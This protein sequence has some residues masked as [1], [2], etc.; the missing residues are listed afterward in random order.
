MVT[1]SPH[2]ITTRVEY[3]VEVPNLDDQGLHVAEPRLALQES[4]TKSLIPSTCRC[5]EERGFKL[6]SLGTELRNVAAYMETIGK[7]SIKLPNRNVDF[8]VAVGFEIVC[9]NMSCADF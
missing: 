5:L 1:H 6:F 2:G 4:G 8:I 3:E 7:S 9:R